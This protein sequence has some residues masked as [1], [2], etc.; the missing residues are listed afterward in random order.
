MGV[1]KR[2]RKLDVASL[3]L[4]L[5]V[6]AG[7]PSGGWPADALKNYTK[8]NVAR[9]ARCSFYDWFDPA[10]EALMEKLVERR[11]IEEAIKAQTQG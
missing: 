5:I 9:I 3:V 7:T 1:V 11:I 8:L 10:F 4:S 2:Q 6:T